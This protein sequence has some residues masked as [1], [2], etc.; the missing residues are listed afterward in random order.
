MRLDEFSVV[1][2]SDAQRT[3]PVPC[4]FPRKSLGV[5]MRNVNTF[6]HKPVEFGQ[7]SEA[8]RPPGTYLPP[9]TDPFSR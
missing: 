5:S 7:L 3:S 1:A 6:V 2:R 9:T 4:D 8:I